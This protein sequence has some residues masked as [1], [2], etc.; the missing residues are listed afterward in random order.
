M[1]GVDTKKKELIGPFKN[2]GREWEPRGEP[3]RVDTH[4]FPDRELGRAVPYGIYDVAANSGWVNVGTDD[5]TAA[6]AV[7]SIRRWWHGAGRAAYPTAGQLLITADVGG[8]N[9][10]RTRTW[11]SELGRFAAETGL[12]VTVCHL[13]PGFEVEPDRAP[14]VLPHHHELARQTPDQPRSGAGCASCAADG[15]LGGA[16]QRSSAVVPAWF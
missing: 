1:I 13:P 15:T 3:V 9:G 12:A 14:A 4:D 16:R 6:F 5:D 7:E 11:K 8:S 2:S 10:Y